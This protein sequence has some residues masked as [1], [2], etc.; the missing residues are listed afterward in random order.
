LIEDSVVGLLSESVSEGG[1]E[2]VAGGVFLEVAG[3]AF[4]RKFLVSFRIYILEGV[5]LFWQYYYSTSPGYGS[6]FQSE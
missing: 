1:E 4:R 6:G 2:S 5:L 3:L